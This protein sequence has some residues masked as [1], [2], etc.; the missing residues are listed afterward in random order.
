MKSMPLT[1]LSSLTVTLLVPALRQDWL[2]RRGA[3]ENSR[4]HSRLARP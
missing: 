4:C 1:L 3:P 2:T